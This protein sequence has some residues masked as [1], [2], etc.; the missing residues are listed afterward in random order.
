MMV[1]AGEMGGE[2]KSEIAS[3]TSLR[4]RADFCVTATTVVSALSENTMTCA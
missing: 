4:Q 1:R 2:D 3:G